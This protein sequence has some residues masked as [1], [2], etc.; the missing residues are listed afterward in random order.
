MTSHHLPSDKVSYYNLWWSYER[1]T[2]IPTF[3]PTKFAL[4][5]LQ[6]GTQKEYGQDVAFHVYNISSALFYKI[7]LC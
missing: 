5:S 7:N 6:P 4:A 2:I 1:G 3:Y